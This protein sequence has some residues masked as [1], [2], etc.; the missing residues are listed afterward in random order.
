MENYG[1]QT[2]L[3]DRYRNAQ[4]RIEYVASKRGSINSNIGYYTP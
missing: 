1:L 4:T 2:Y 3:P